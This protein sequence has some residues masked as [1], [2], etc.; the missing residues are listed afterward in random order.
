MKFAATQVIG[1]M[2]NQWSEGEIII[3]HHSYQQNMIVTPHHLKSNWQ[4]PS[5]EQLC[6]TDLALIFELKPDIVILGSG[7]IQ[8]FPPQALFI[9]ALKQG[10][11]LEVMASP[12][13]C[14]TYNVLASEDR[15]VIAGI[16]V[17]KYKTS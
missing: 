15:Q 16:M 13:A 12:A 10:I 3:N 1:N 2:I 7:K 11:G 5:F 9:E 4:V 6:I 17:N 14:R 8:I